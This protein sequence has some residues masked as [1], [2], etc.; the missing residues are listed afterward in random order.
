MKKTVGLIL[1]AVMVIAAVVFLPT[2]TEAKKKKNNFSIKNLAPK[3][4][5]WW[6]DVTYIITKNERLVFKQLTTD[7]E[8]DIFMNAFWIHRDPTTGTEENEFKEEHYKRKR[9]VEQLYGRPKIGKQGWKT[10]RGKVHIILGAPLSIQRFTSYSQVYPTEVWHYQVKP[11]GGIPPAF[12][13]VFFD[14][15]GTGE[16]V[17]YSPIGDGPQKLLIGFQGKPDAYAEAFEQLKNFDHF[18]AMT[19]ISLIPGE[20]RGPGQPSMTSDFLL[21]DIETAP[22]KAVEDIYARKFLQYKGIVEVDYSVNYVL[23]KSLSHLTLDKSGYHVFNFLVDFKKLTV[24][25]YDELYYTNIEVFGS[26]TD[27]TGKT[28]YQFEKT[29]NIR[30]DD[31]QFQTIRNSSF[32]ISDQFPVIPGQYRLSILV[33]NTNSKE[34][35]AYETDLDVPSPTSSELHLSGL[36]LGYEVKNK[37]LPVTT[38]R[39]IP[40]TT[41]LGGFQV[42][43]E[44]RFGKGD[45]LYIF[46]QL[47]GLTDQ[48][49]NNGEIRLKIRGDRNFVKEIPKKLSDFP[50]NRSDF[51][52]EVPLTG[53][54]SD[55]YNLTVTVADQGGNEL[56]L[57]KERFMITPLSTIGRPQTFSKA[58]SLNRDA[59]FAFILGNQYMNIKKT[60]KALPLMR[61][62]YNLNPQVLQFALGLARLYMDLKRYDKIEPM[63]KP[64]ADQEKP[65]YQLFFL[66]GSVNQKTGKYAE[67]VPYFRRLIVYHGYNVDVLNSLASCHYNL[68]EYDEARKA[69]EHSLKVDAK[70]EKVKKALEGLKNDNQKQKQT[71]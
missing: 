46:F 40:F 12:K 9:E 62:A 43:P 26:L 18:L 44:N 65:D 55:Y 24:D 10:D 8:R 20:S 50:T 51:L 61:K 29:Y 59:V 41:P 63:L 13:V 60:G 32:A 33:K 25:Q 67:A 5:A 14:R 54:P 23:S 4:Q 6:D 71:K 3:Y 36:L 19:S 66:L 2:G 17:L 28:V 42:D 68:G 38:G 27:K 7:R 30:L 35:T 22:Q 56:A 21:R 57:Q 53:Y 64:F 49:K 1:T 58:S 45:I 16:Y 52:L 39:G 48:L 31:Q 15:F 34:F 37:N 47:R 69:W 70:Q 11:R